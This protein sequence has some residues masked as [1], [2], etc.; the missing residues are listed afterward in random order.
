MGVDAVDHEGGDGARGVV[1]A[2]VA[3]ALEVV[4]D[5]LV[6]V[7][8]VLALGEVV[9]VDLI[10]LVDDL[11]HELAGLHVVIGVLEDDAAAAGLLAGGGELL[12]LREELEVDEGEKLVAG[13]ALGVGG[14]GAP[15][16]GLGDGG[17]VVILHELQLL[18]LVVDDLEEE[19]PA[20]LG[21]VLGVAIDAGIL[22]HDVLDGLD[23]VANGHGLRDMVSQGPERS[24]KGRNPFAGEIR[25]LTRAVLC[26]AEGYGWMLGPLACTRG[27][28][29]G[30]GATDGCGVRL[31]TRAVLV[32]GCRQ[33]SA[34]YRAR[35]QADLTEP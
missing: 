34:Q 32:P 14:P 7:A 13:D 29:A 20:K 33:S 3:C 21:N 11:P 19:H 23:G 24:E 10:D 25:L 15:A 5:L 31:L 12:E 1:F 4:Q 9:E 16:E 18:V 35:E 8:E 17:A 26:W 22:A 2:G 6:D 30:A 27:A 28:C